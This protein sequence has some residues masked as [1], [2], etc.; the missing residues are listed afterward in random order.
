MKTTKKALLLALCAVLLVVSTVFAT[1]AYLVDT[2]SVTNTF[3]VGKVAIS[4]DEAKVDEYGVEVAGAERVTE[5]EYKLIPGHKYVK[6]PT[7]TVAEDSEAS[8]I[9]MLVTISDLA[10]VKAVLGVDEGTTG[11]FL[12]QY[13]VQGWDSSIWKTTGVVVEKDDTATYEFRYYTTVS[14]VDAEAKTLEALFTDI[15]VPE[16]IDNDDLAK[17]AELKIDVVAHAIQADG[18]PSEDAAWAAFTT[19]YTK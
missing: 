15:V 13:F 4:L 8:Y 1:M 5:N 12:P 7:V 14:T 17:L 6:D 9:R 2:D 10:D 19:N 18:F 11:Y 3:A 16:Q